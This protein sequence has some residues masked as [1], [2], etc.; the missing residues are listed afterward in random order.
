MNEC[1]AE[2]SACFS[3]SPTVETSTREFGGQDALHLREEQVARPDDE[4]NEEIQRRFAD[5]R[6]GRPKVGDE[7][8][9][10]RL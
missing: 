10:T 6:T 8:A 2:C 3:A 4:I 1:K 7:A 9:Q 5:S